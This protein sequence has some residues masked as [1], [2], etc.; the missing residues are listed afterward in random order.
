[1]VYEIR[2][3]INKSQT[4]LQ[5]LGEYWMN[6]MKN[7]IKLMAYS[8]EKERDKRLYKAC[9]DRPMCCIIWK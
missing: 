7:I 5:N 2:K 4:V 1:M 9:A 6:N 8:K 3:Y